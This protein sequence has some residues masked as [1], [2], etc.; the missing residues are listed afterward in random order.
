M[1]EGVRLSES[2]LWDLQRAFFVRQDPRAWSRG[3]VPS[4]VTSNA[5][6]ARAAARVIGGFL[7]D[8]A[9]GRLGALDDGAPIHVLEL[10][11]GSGRFAYGVLRSLEARA[12]AGSRTGPGVRY[13]ITDFDA[14]PV[15]ALRGNARLQPFVERGL[16]DFAVLDAEAP[17]E[18]VLLESGATLQPSPGG[19]PLVAVANYV[20][21]GIRTDAFEVRRGKLFESHVRLQCEPGVDLTDPASLPQ[22]IVSFKAAPL[23]PSPYGDAELDSLLQ[24]VAVRL[25]EGHFLFPAAALRLLR[26]LRRVGGGRFLFLAADRGHVHADALLG[27][28]APQMMRHG[29]ISLDVNF[30][31]LA[32]HARASQ[33]IA[34]LPAHH[35]TH[36]A[37]VGLLW[38]CARADMSRTSE[39][40]HEHFEGGGP[41]DLFLLQATL[42]RRTRGLG[43]ERGLAWLRVSAWDPEV[44]LSC[45]PTF[46]DHVDQAE[47]TVRADLLD[48]ARRV[49][50]AYFPVDGDRDIP[51]ALAELLQALD[52]LP[53]AA[54]LCE[55]S[56]RLHGRNPETLHR[57][58][59]CL[60]GLDRVREAQALLD[61]AL[62][63]APDFEDARA[64]NAALAA[65]LRRRGASKR[66]RRGTR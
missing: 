33:G 2:K 20:L 5:F 47:P 17:G 10:G 36:L 18:V 16:L 48:A 54:E 56:L 15:E 61:E 3:R 65:D 57:L 6:I 23:A 39:A 30:H 59:T 24:D 8:A 49:R 19:N 14:A 1:E 22:L 52:A 7:D 32:E 55:E 4:Y 27:L 13:V 21:D 35:P 9:A 45:A 43:V 60:S 42:E 26:H 44:F 11:A 25:D 29:S 31:V 28:D 51:L 38:G 34:L 12:S 53:E 50:D 66:G 46:L 40:Y 62:S 64:M 41:E 37:T 63:L 58:A